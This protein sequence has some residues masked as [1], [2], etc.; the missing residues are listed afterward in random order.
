MVLMPDPL[1]L[2]APPGLRVLL[3]RVL[4]AFTVRTG[5]RFDVRDAEVATTS[6]IAGPPRSAI[7]AHRRR[8]RD[9]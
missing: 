2:V 6:E 7:I 5:I 1:H 3:T 4:A 9:L 8:A